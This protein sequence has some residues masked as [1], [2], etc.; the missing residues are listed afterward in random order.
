MIDITLLSAVAE[1]LL[2]SLHQHENHPDVKELLSNMR[3]MAIL[4][5]AIDWHIKEPEDLGMGRWSMESNLGDLRD[6]AEL[7]AQFSLALEG[8]SW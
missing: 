3:F 7:F 4:Q 1:R 2:I 8:R 6:V 5:N